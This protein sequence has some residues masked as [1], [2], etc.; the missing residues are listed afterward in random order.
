MRE[1]K[2]NNLLESLAADTRLPL[3]RASLDALISKPIE[4]TGDA[5]GQITRVVGRIEL[6]TSKNPLAAK[7]K[8]KSIR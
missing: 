3:D 4:F 8:P 1:G 2:T 7:Y 5:Q 6:I